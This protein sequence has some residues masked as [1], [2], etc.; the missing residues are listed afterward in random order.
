M[1]G[2]WCAPRVRV[3]RSGPAG[4]DS[5]PAVCPVWRVPGNCPRFSAVVPL[6]RRFLP[7]AGF[8]PLRLKKKKCVYACGAGLSDG[9]RPFIRRGPRHRFRACV[10]CAVGVLLAWLALCC[11]WLGGARCGGVR[12]FAVSRSAAGVW[13]NSCIVAA[14]RSLSVCRCLWRVASCRAERGPAGPERSGTRGAERR[15]NSTIEKTI[16]RGFHTNY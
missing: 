15:F 2:L 11:A 6:A 12:S 8:F 16:T 10:C 3:F 13:A 7:L 9:L 4:L 14:F 1:V 5:A